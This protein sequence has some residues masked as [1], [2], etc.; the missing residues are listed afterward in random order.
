MQV[1][2]QTSLVAQTFRGGRHERQRFSDKGRPPPT[3]CCSVFSGNR[4]RCI[5]ICVLA[6]SLAILPGDVNAHAST[7]IHNHATS[8]DA[9][10]HFLDLRQGGHNTISSLTHI[11]T[12]THL[13]LL[14]VSHSTT[15][16]IDAR[17]RESSRSTNRILTSNDSV[18]TSHAT[19]RLE[20]RVTVVDRC[21][22]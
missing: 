8:P 7:H 6:A 1:L 12:H 4:L 5:Y 22:L 11:H 10:S 17:D 2:L 21:V 19:V 16:G 18:C 3:D 14:T 9:S 13:T 15:V 20:N